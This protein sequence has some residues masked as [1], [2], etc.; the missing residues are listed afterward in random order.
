MCD[1]SLH[2][3]TSR[4][5]KVG[6]RLISTKFNNSITT[7][8]AAMEDLSVPVCLLP[9]TEIA[10]EKDIIEYRHSLLPNRKLAE[11]VARFRQINM[12][13]PNTHHDAL[14]FPNGRVVLLNRLCEGQRA[15]VLQLPAVSQ[16]VREAKEQESDSLVA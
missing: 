9:G 1:Y 5:A 14:E 10:F 2:L 15:T 11:K 3:L 7:G 6:D 16:S 12:D 4:P 8:F 13:N